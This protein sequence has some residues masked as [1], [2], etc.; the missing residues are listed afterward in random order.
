MERRAGGDGRLRQLGQLRYGLDCR[1]RI[2]VEGEENLA[3]GGGMNR[4]TCACALIEAQVPNRRHREQHQHIVAVA[5]AE[6]DRLAGNAGERLEYG[7][8]SRDTDGV[9]GSGAQSDECDAKRVTLGQWVVG[10]QLAGTERA[11]ADERWRQ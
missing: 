4:Y 11:R 10:Q 9:G 7:A 2:S 1:V 3:H 5:H 6:V 8:D